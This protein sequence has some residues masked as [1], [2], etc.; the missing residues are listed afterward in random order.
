MAH[1]W[2]ISVKGVAVVEGR[3]VLL[4]NERA[5]WELPGGRLE[6]GDPSLEDTLVREMAEETGWSV[7]VGPLLDTWIFQPVPDARIVIVTYGC[8]VLTPDRVPVVSH[9]HDQLALVPVEQV[10][11]LHMPEGYKRSIAAWLRRTPEPGQDPDASGRP[12]PR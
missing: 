5:E 11:G 3:V 6:A 9:E 10:P 4:R 2:P 1:T 12:A 8:T 7:R